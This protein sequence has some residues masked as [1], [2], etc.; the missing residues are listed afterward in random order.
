LGQLL[1]AVGAGKKC[2]FIQFDK[3]G[4][5]YHERLALADHLSH[6]VRVHVTGLDRIDPVSGRFR[7]GVLDADQAEAQ[8]GLDL[9]AA[10]V[11]GGY[12]LVILDEFNHLVQLGLATEAAT[13][14][15]LAAKHPDVELILTGRT[16]PEFVVEAADL[17]TEIQEVRHYF[18]K[19]VPARAG[20]DF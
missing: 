8:R 20:F 19:G 14:A 11:A 13:K 2:C 9:A 18:R 12:D 7:F 5:H 10:A 16:P 15:V 17:I 4:T 1:R 6:A 3:G